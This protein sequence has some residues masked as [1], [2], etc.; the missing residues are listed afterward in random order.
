LR[1]I[2]RFEDDTVAAEFGQENIL[3]LTGGAGEGFLEDTFG[4]HK[5]QPVMQGRRLMFQAVY[6][7]F[8][9]PYGPKRPAA[10]AAEVSQHHAATV[11]PWTNRLYVHP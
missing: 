9:L 3:R 7:M 10:S 5:G 4:I 2:R 6:S 1:E 8:P 11:D